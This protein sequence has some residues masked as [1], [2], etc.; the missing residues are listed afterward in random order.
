MPVQHAGIMRQG[1]ERRRLMGNVPVVAGS[2]LVLYA[3][4]TQE[5]TILFVFQPREALLRHAET[6]DQEPLWTAGEYRLVELLIAFDTLFVCVCDWR[7]WLT[8]NFN[9]QTQP[10]ARTNRNPCLQRW[11]RRK[12]RRRS[13]RG[14][15]T[16]YGGGSRAA[17]GKSASGEGEAVG[18]R[19]FFCAG[20]RTLF[21][22]GYKD[23]SPCSDLLSP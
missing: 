22:T 5:L 3:L 17:R 13:N 4:C 15:R 6:S 11:K 19:M 8:W 10:G 20:A 12:R 23:L 1:A 9:F 2:S 14:L 21:C 18:G 7:W 16:G